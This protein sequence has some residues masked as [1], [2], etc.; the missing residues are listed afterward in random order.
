M[1]LRISNFKFQLADAGGA[2]FRQNRRS[3]SARAFT[4]IEIMIAIAVFT[5]VIAAIYAT[6]AVIMKSSQVSR[7]VAAQAQRQRITLRTI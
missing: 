1:K 5:M 4:L 6:W 7:D 3:P 2:S